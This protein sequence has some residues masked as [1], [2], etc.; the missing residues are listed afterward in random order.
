[1][2]YD[3]AALTDVGRVRG[4]N[5]D[6]VQAVPD[7]GLA[8]LADGMGGYNAGEVA[9]AMAV[10]HVVADFVQWHSDADADTSAEQVQAVIEE[11]VSRLNQSIWKTS[12]ERSECAGMGTTL[13]VLALWQD[14]A[15]LGHV[16]DS[17]AYLC[18]EGSLQQ[19]TRDHSLLQEQLDAGIIRVEELPLL[20]AFRNFITRALGAEESVQADFQ[21]VSL[22]PGDHILLCSDGLTGM[23]P[24]EQIAAVLLERRPVVEQAQEL[25]DMANEQ[26]GHDNISVVLVSARPDPP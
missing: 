7:A 13:V 24:D 5:E 26:G 19:L 25:I 8:V 15:V 11:I 21:T 20:A 10:E 12:R 22:K 3:F 1:M 14:L 6:A 18:R 4:N 23:L 17:R 16:G 2:E 9:S